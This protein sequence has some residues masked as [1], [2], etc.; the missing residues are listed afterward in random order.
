MRSIAIIAFLV[1]LTMPCIAVPDSVVTG[2]YKVTFDLGTPKEAYKVNVAAPKTTESLSGDIRTT[3]NIEFINNSGLTRRAGLILTSYENDVI[4]PTQDEL[5]RLEEN[6]LSQLSNTYN[7]EAARRKID[8]YDGAV[9]SGTTWIS[10]EVGA[11]D[12]YSA[13]YRPS[14]TMNVGLYSFYPWDEGTLS[15][16]KTVHVEMIN[17]TS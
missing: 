4:I 16:L 17:S 9:A 13:V 5:V 1:L 3:F 11:V 6:T 7:I 2:P 14:L 10:S 12:V 8:G 15:L